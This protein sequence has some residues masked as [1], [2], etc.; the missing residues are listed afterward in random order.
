M[1]NHWIIYVHFW[2]NDEIIRFQ[3]P[4]TSWNEISISLFD[5]SNQICLTLIPPFLVTGKLHKVS[6]ISSFQSEGS[7]FPFPYN[8]AWNKS[9]MYWNLIAKLVGGPTFGSARNFLLASV[10]ESTPHPGCNGHKWR[11]RLGFPT[12]H[13][14]I[15]VVTSQ[16]PGA[17][18]HPFQL[19]AK[20]LR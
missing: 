15:L 18:G 5:V 7:P 12:K 10:Y 3:P 8:H 13:G 1:E 14:I 9:G 11:F 2:V 6:Q 20:A 4:I 19:L 17:R 16:H